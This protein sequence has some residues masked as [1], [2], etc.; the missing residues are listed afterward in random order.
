MVN[1]NRLFEEIELTDAFF[2]RLLIVPFERTISDKDKDPKLAQKIAATELAGVFN[3]ILDGLRRLQIQ[4]DFSKCASSEKALSAYRVRSDSVLYF[5]EEE[6]YQQHDRWTQLKPVYE[7]YRT[8]C[9]ENGMKPVSARKF[10]E[11]LSAARFVIEK[12]NVGKVVYL[13]KAPAEAEA[14]PF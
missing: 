9:F 3:W 6:G 1:A 12:K 7:A 14:A 10:A 13:Q 5:I 11:R 8:F 2:R 4:G